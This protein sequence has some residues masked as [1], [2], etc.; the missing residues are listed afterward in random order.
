MAWF[1][2]KGHILDFGQK[3]F[4][5][6][7]RSEDTKGIIALALGC[8]F[9]MVIGSEFHMGQ[10]TDDEHRD[11]SCHFTVKSLPKTRP[12]S[13]LVLS[14]SLA[15]LPVF[16]ISSSASSGSITSPTQM[17]SSSSSSIYQWDYPC[18]GFQKENVFFSKK[19]YLG[20]RSRFT[21]VFFV[22]WNTNDI[23]TL[24]FI[25]YIWECWFEWQLSWS[26]KIF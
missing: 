23:S 18:E 21:I 20:F 3:T 12:S 17:R 14:S 24:I 6:L 8:V 9:P 4:S 2:R 13:V 16:S 7:V 19:T 10:Y 5:D 25:W 11:E 1:P 22:R 15:W 26:D